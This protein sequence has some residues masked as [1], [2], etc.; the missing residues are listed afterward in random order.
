MTAIIAAYVLAARQARFKKSPLEERRTAFL[1][2]AL[3]AQSDA[4]PS[5]HLALWES[6]R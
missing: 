6:L 5:T 1:R 2:L 3:Q 4:A